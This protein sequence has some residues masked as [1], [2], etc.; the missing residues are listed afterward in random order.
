[1]QDDSLSYKLRAS[2]CRLMLHMHVDRDPQVNLSMA[3]FKVK[4]SPTITIKISYKKLLVLQFKR[5]L[6]KQHL[7]IKTWY[8]GN[9]LI[10]VDII[11]SEWIKVMKSLLFSYYAHSM[12]P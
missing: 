6:L 5:N 4:T 3:K 11:M 8:Y 2:F 12:I 7:V 10:Y 1:M 9:S